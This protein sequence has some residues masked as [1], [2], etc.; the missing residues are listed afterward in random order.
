[1]KE[2]E[3]RERVPYGTKHF[4]L[5]VN[6]GGGAVEGTGTPRWG[7]AACLARVPQNVG[8]PLNALHSPS[9]N[10]SALKDSLSPMPTHSDTPTLPHALDG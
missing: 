10:A 1:M 6:Y 3:R 9:L 7:G 5:K 8:K 4:G 2:R